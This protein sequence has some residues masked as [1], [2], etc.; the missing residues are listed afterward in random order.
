MGL[1]LGGLQPTLLQMSTLPPISGPPPETWIAAGHR[2]VLRALWCVLAAVLVA[3]SFTTVPGVRSQQGFNAF[4]DGWVQNGV[5]A[6]ATLLI[7]LRAALTRNGRWAWAGIAVG[8]GLYTL[9][10]TLYF[11]WVQYDETIP[12]PSV[13]DAAWLASYAFL[14]G[15]LLGLARPRIQISQR[16][17]WLD[18]TVGALGISSAAAVWLE[19]VLHHTQGS[20]TAVLTT[21]AYPVSDL[22]LLVVVIGTCGLLGWRPD[23]VWLF[24]GLGLIL[25]AAAD[26]IYV[27]RVA[28]ESYTAGTMLDPLWAVAAVLIAAAA[29]RGPRPQRH[30]QPY[31]WSML[32]V[33]SAFVLCSLG[34][35][36][37][38]TWRSVP[39][40]SVVL[41]SLTILAGLTRAAITFHDVQSLSVHREQAR[42][43][44]LTGLGNRRHFYEVVQSRIATLADDE[45]V[46]VLLLDLDRFKDVNDALGHSVG[47]R[48]LV[49]VG[50]R[51]AAQLRHGDVLVR[52][53]GDEFAIMLD[54]SS[55]EAAHALSERLR[56]SLQAAFDVDA[57][58]VY[59]DASVGI[60][61]CPDV[62]TDVEGLLQRADIAMYQAKSDRTGALVYESGETDLTAQL[63]GIEE[64]RRAID[65]SELVLH[66]QPKVDLRTGRLD[67][68][69]ALV[70]WQHPERGLLAPDAFIPQAERYG[71]MRLLTAGVL[72]QALDQVSAWRQGDGP[73]SVAVNVSASNLLDTDLPEQIA[74]MLAMRELPGEALTVEITEGVL[75][76]DPDRA[77]RVL[78][79]LRALGVH[80]SIDDYGTGYSSL[81]RL[82]DLPVTELKL[83]RSFVQQIDHDA[84]SD[85]I[86]ESTI[87]LAHSL[88]L[89]LVAEG[90]ETE[91]ACRRLAAMGC[92]I[93]QGYHLGRPTSADAFTGTTGPWVLAGAG[94]P[95]P[96]RPAVP[97]TR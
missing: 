52:L 39:V 95:E 38:G 41:A 91:S 22:V 35:L 61:M 63:R 6:T 75:M 17:L 29:L 81:A 74:T 26:T 62:A 4:I 60:A 58:T 28:S 69:E 59:I 30:R 10:N 19:Y 92:D 56:A 37:V 73:T 72:S 20:Q 24:L 47:D 88:G 90:I 16:T 51:L 77:S 79:S 2:R 23:G 78:H 43:D 46:A 5:L 50:A 57:V 85:A 14:Y 64:L 89:R 13:A 65:R 70:R 3:Y 33:P 96:R 82:R 68:V 49:R 32:V 83:D 44:E 12:Y 80:I 48:L 15:G 7:A 31:G 45:Q 9:G 8:V 86:V 53:G 93:G 25:F 21:M 1:D 76:A 40:S 11:G 87:Q 34:L 67:G 84:R 27:L 71:F 55:R 54:G 97:Q 36:V 66:Y 42:T 18:G 94:V